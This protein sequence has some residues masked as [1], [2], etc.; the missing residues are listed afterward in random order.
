MQM[1]KNDF[2]RNTEWIAEQNDRARK[3][4]GVGKTMSGCELRL[5]KRVFKCCDVEDVIRELRA[6]DDFAIVDIE[7]DLGKFSV[8]SLRP[9]RDFET[10]V[11][12]MCYESLNRRRE[13]NVREEE[14]IRII[15]VV[16]LEELGV[17]AYSRR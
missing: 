11:F 1:L 3:I 14:V 15:K 5:S 9:G 2:R 12:Y 6:F 16:L 13:G 17:P 4:C 7:H 10:L 8:V